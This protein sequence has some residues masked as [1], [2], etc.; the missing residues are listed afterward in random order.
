MR[1][2]HHLLTQ[3]LPAMV[4]TALSACEAP[5]SIAPLL[6]SHRQEED[7]LSLYGQGSKSGLITACQAPGYRQFDFWIG[8]WEVRS[9]RADGGINPPQPSIIERELDGC[10]IEENW[11]GTAR[12][13]NTYDAASRQYHQQYIDASGNHMLLTGGLLADGSMAMTGTTFYSCASCPN[14]IFP[15]VNI[16][17]WTAITP[18]SVRQLNRQINGLNGQPWQTGIGF[19]GRYRRDASV[20]LRPTPETGPCS[21]DPLH[22]QVD[23]AV[24]EWVISNGEATGRDVANGRGPVTAVVTREL[25]GCLIEEHVT[26]PGGYRGW[27]FNGWSNSE[28]IWVRTYVNNLGERVF[29]RGTLDGSRLVLT[30]THSSAAGESTLVR[31][32]WDAVTPDRVVETWA[33]SRDGGAT[34]QAEK[35][36][37]RL[38]RTM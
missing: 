3:L 38:R 8:R 13:I 4:L 7:S 21:S 28:D 15:L 14:G 23:F 27:S 29:L 5:S 36:V 11:T 33:V 2:T 30:G 18:D 37:V 1:P 24:G 25:A 6:A 35:E 9:I 10:V 20:A 32:T 16:W 22:R 12:S 26:G 31:M 19:D 34:Y 17:Q